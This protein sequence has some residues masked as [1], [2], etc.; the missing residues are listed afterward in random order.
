MEFD[1]SKFTSSADN[2]KAD[3]DG[4]SFDSAMFDFNGR[5]VSA[6]APTSEQASFENQQWA[7]SMESSKAFETP[8]KVTAS[9]NDTPVVREKSWDEEQFA[10]HD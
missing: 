4:M 9:L 2:Q 1:A 7:P 5:S 8:E 10:G 6:P 3:V